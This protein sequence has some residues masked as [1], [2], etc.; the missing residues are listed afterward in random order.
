MSYDPVT[1]LEHDHVHLTK[2][3]ESIRESVQS[4]LRGEMQP[5]DLEEDFLELLELLREELYEHFDK[6]EQALFPYIL[7]H[8]ADTE[9]AIRGLEKGHDRM[10]GVATRMERMITGDDET[11][12]EGFDGLVALFARFDANYVKHARDEARLLRS[13][14]D[15]LSPEQR[16]EIAELIREL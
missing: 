11:F 12:G 1:Q 13:L 15:R 7:A 10:C 3:V 8:F 6:E 14:Q 2:M 16:T 5:T 4:C 9:E